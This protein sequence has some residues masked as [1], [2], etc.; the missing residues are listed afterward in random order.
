MQDTGERESDLLL[1]SSGPLGIDAKAAV[2]GTAPEYLKRAPQRNDIVP[3]KGTAV[4]DI[5]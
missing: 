3:R 4:S 2:A 1:G 5:Q